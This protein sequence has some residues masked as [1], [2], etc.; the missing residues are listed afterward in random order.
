MSKKRKR[1]WKWS[2]EARARLSKRLKGKPP[3][4]IINGVKRE[5]PPQVPHNKKYECEDRRIVKCFLWMIHRCYRSKRKCRFS[6]TSQSFKEFVSEMGP[7]PKSIKRPSV[8]RKDHDFGYVKGNMQWEEYYFNVWKARR[9]E[10][11]D[12]QPPLPTTIGEEEEIPF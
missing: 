8:G 5:R 4:N 12:S 1:G 9:P 2:D 3:V 11:Q 7:I 6:R 10:R